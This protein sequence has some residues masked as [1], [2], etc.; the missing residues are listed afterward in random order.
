MG[1]HDGELIGET[2]NGSKIRSIVISAT[3]Y[4][5]LWMSVNDVIENWICENEKNDFV[6]VKLPQINS[7]HLL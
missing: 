4:E 6:F 7:A 2:K 1:L 5:C 3:K